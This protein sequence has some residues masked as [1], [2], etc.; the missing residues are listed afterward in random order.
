MN[1]SNMYLLI[2]PNNIEISLKKTGLSSYNTI[3]SF[4]NLT[5]YNDYFKMLLNSVNIISD[6]YYFGSILQLK[7]SL[8]ALLI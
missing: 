3:S 7:Y 2:L 1:F 5:R 8:V 4:T 6:F